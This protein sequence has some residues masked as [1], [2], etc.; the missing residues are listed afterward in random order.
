MKKYKLQYP[1]II[2][3]AEGKVIK[4]IDTYDYEDYSIFNSRKRKIKQGSES[5]RRL[6]LKGFI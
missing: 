5:I 4:V 6:S 2:K 3:N 1:V